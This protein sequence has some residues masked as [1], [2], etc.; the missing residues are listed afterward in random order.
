M[1]NTIFFATNLKNKRMQ[2][3]V[4]MVKNNMQRALVLQGGGSLGA[5]EA[6][7]F[8]ALYY[9]IKKDIDDDENVFDVVAGT[10]IGAINAAFL[11][12]YVIKRMRE[13][14]KN[15][16]ESWNGSAE[17]LEEFWK[18]RLASNINLNKW[19][20]FSWDEKSWTLAWD[21]L[22]STNPFIATG[23]A[24]RRYYSAKESI[25]SGASNVFLP[26]LPPTIDSKFFDNFIVPNIRYRY[27]NS[28][29]RGSINEAIRFPIGT[30]LGNMEPRLLAISVDVEEG[31]TVTF[32]SYD[33]DKATDTRRS[34][35]GDYKPGP[36][37]KNGTYERTIKY[38]K[39]IMVEHIL[40]SASVPEHYDYTLVPKKYDY[41]KTEEEKLVDIENYHLENY[42]RFWDGGVLSNTPLREL[43]ESHKNYWKSAIPDLEVYIIDVWPSVDG[44]PVPSD[45]DGIRDRKNDLT[46]QDMTPYDEKVA[47]IVSDYF[48]FV[49]ELGKL[50]V[51]AIG[52]IG[53]VKKKND[54]QTRLNGVYSTKAKSRHRTG[55]LRTY[56]ELVDERFDITKVIRIERSADKNDIANKWCDFSLGTISK[57]FEQGTLDALKTLAKEIM[58][59]KSIQLKDEKVKEEIMISKSIEDARTQLDLFSSYAKEQGANYD[60]IQSTES[61]KVMLPD[62]M[63]T[64]LSVTT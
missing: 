28:R 56:R 31:E 46:Y 26:N 59:S 51:E 3:T 62:L 14:N 63:S 48:N 47:N 20:P 9:W 58:R 15:G 54:L 2:Y 29:L 34:E 64:I 8:S 25:I 17:E 18:S 40:A 57:L 38:D 33:K 11:V 7:V 1:I 52:G 41:T 23:E 24:A 53:D 43:I 12:S 50:A 16:V 55:E 49:S 13:E 45:L 21:V 32:D 39:G 60:L 42:S 44:Y 19:W 6:G 61:V 30:S 10:S 27:D 36:D 4:T 22:N 5:Y 35:Y 37:G